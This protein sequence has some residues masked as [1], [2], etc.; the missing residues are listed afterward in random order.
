MS[1]ASVTIGSS[2][3]KCVPRNNKAKFFYERFNQFRRKAPF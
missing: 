3:V 1:T 2:C